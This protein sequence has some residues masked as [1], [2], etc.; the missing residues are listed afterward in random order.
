MKLYAHDLLAP[1]F[2]V[3]INGKI[4]DRCR[5]ADEEMGE[6]CVYKKSQKGSL[7][8][9]FQTEILKGNV[10]L[11]PKSNLMHVL[12]TIEINE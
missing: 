6:I 2:N 7:L 4:N 1:Y 9:N 5:W 10:K 8:S 11:V 12:T 3:Y